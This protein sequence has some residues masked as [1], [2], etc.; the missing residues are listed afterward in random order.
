MAPLVVFCFFSLSRVLTASHQHHHGC[1]RSQGKIVFQYKRLS[2]MNS[3]LAIVLT[4]CLTRK[5]C[6]IL[7]IFTPFGKPIIFVFVTSR[8]WNLKKRSRDFAALQRLGIIR[9]TWEL[10][11]EYKTEVSCLSRL[12]MSIFALNDSTKMKQIVWNVN[13]L[14]HEKM[15]ELS[16]RTVNSLLFLTKQ[17]KWKRDYNKKNV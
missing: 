5:N 9:I 11:C 7:F 4:I 1:A 13:C 12:I 14:Q 15:L 3:K 16:N 2:I 6:M 8:K 17:T 10:I